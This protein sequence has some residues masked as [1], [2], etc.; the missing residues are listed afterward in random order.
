[1]LVLLAIL[2]GAALLGAA[3]THHYVERHKRLQSPPPPPAPIAQITPSTRA[4]L[5]PRR[6]RTAAQRLKRHQSKK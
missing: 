4:Y 6:S 3:E 5:G 2:A 1:M